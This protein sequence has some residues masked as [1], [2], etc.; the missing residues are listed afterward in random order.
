MEERQLHAYS[1][2]TAKGR[3]VSQPFA[4]HFEKKLRHV[5]PQHLA[6]TWYQGIPRNALARNAAMESRCTMAFG[7]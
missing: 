2:K 4:D 6:D 1:I 3:D 5:V 7:Q